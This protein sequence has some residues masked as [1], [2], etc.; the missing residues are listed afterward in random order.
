VGSKDVG[1]QGRIKPTHRA[2]LITG[3]RPWRRSIVDTRYFFVDLFVNGS[4]RAD[5]FGG[6]CKS[7]EDRHSIIQRDTLVSGLPRR[8]DFVVEGLVDG[9]INGPLRL[10][11]PSFDDLVGGSQVP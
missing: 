4:M 11:P 3:S 9:V 8:R 7:G 10:L 1:S 5:G 6:S 2:V